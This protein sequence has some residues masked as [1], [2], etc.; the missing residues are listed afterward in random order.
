MSY[1]S[2]TLLNGEN[3]LYKGWVSSWYFAPA[4]VLAVVGAVLLACAFIPENGM[5]SFH[6]DNETAGILMVAGA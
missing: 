3:I 1:T 2:R 6:A 4:L 5:I